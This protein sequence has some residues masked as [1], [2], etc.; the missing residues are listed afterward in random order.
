[1]EFEG[2]PL[3]IGFNVQYFLDVLGCL[4]D[5]KVILELGEALSPCI[6]KVDGRDDVCFVIM[7]IRLD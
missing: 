3:S 4:Q 7:P 5:E 6:V 2:E 1:M